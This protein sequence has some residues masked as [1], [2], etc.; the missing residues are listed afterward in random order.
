[1]KKRQK[2]NKSFQKFN[3]KY[4]HQKKVEYKQYNQF[5]QRKCNQC[6]SS[7]SALENSGKNE[8][9]CPNCRPSLDDDDNKSNRIMNNRDSSFK[10]EGNNYHKYGY[11]PK[12]FNSNKKKYGLPASQTSRY[13]N[14][15]KNNFNKDLSFNSHRFGSKTLHHSNSNFISRQNNRMSSPKPFLRTKK[16]GL[17]NLNSKFKP[18]KDKDNFGIK[19][20]N[21]KN[22]N[23][24]FEVE[25]NS[26][27]ESKDN[28]SEEES[29]EKNEKSFSKKEND[30]FRN[31]S[32]GDK[33]N[34][35]DNNFDDFDKD[36]DNKNDSDD[37]KDEIKED[38]NNQEEDD[39]EGGD[40]D[41]DFQDKMNIKAFCYYDL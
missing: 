1:M 26:V 5:I 6:G 10:R 13:W 40:F 20:Y 27:E 37:D 36:D 19:K 33:S 2:M 41:V 28:D 32:D 30:L 9:Y 7:F 25:L 29:E 11:R 34:E 39:N 24:D 35:N 15:G 18:N 17:N 23:D 12:N 31:H 14:K 3:Y 38:E 22:L 8:Y 4:G 21:E 16:F